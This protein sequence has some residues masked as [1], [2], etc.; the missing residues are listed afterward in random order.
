MTLDL[1]AVR[2][3]TPGCVTR[4]HLNNA[5]AALM[6]RPVSTAIQEHLMLEADIGGYEAAKARIDA[7]EQIRTFVEALRDALSVNGPRASST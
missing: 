2:A 4:I 5:G 1:A 7:I 3:D 6:P